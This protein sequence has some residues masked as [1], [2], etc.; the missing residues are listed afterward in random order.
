VREREKERERERDR[1]RA[2]R[3]ERSSVNYIHRG[4][5]GSERARVTVMQMAVKRKH[6]SLGSSRVARYKRNN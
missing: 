5:V 4:V 1:K 2:R 3:K 6:T